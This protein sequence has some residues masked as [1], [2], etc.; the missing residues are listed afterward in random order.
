MLSYLFGVEHD[1]AQIFKADGSDPLFVSVES[2]LVDASF[3]H[4]ESLLLEQLDKTLPCARVTHFFARVGETRSP[5]WHEFVFAVLV[6]DIGNVEFAGD[7][8]FV[9]AEGVE[10]DRERM[11]EGHRCQRL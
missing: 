6:L 5:H 2:V 9:S 7:L 8:W 4:Q 3:P 11:E 10:D 1:D